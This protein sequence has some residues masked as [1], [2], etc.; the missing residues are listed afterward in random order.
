MEQRMKKKIL[1]IVISSF[2]FTN[3]AFAADDEASLGTQAGTAARAI[4]GSTEE[5]YAT[6]STKIMEAEKKIEAEAQDVFK[7]LREQWDKIAVQVQAS[8]HQ[9]QE[10]MQKQWADFQKSFYQKND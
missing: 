3:V 8:T 6:Q 5:A 7:A 9:L 4:K 10:E 2:L 1:G